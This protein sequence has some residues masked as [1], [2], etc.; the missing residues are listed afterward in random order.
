[1]NLAIWK[2]FE[3]VIKAMC[4]VSTGRKE[5]KDYKKRGLKDQFG[6]HSVTDSL[7]LF[8]RMWRGTG[9][10]ETGRKWGGRCMGGRRRGGG[11]V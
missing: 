2:S 1:V 4:Y 11:E 5:K 8:A 10:K 6:G 7:S 9:G 3:S